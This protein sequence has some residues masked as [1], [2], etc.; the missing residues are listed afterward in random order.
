M[1]EPG[2]SGNKGGRPKGATNKCSTEF[3]VT[4]TKLLDDNADNIA[5]WLKRVAE[6][7][8]KRNS[9]GE[10]VMIGADPGKALHLLAQLAEFAAPKLSR[11]EVSG[12][13]G[14]DIPTSITIQHVKPDATGS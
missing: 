10:V 14:G 2:K 8:P 6:G 7:R 5:F 4:I 1:F 3:R 13:N 11:T 9:E 12:P